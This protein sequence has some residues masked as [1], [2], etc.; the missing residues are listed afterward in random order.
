[1]RFLLAALALWSAAAFAQ[2]FPSKPVR[3]VPFGTAGGPVDTLARMYA[4]KLRVRW[5]QP[6][7]VEPRPGASGTL[8][9]DLV[10]KS[11]PD[12]ATF[13]FTLSL[14]HINNAVLQKNIP[15][16]PFRDFEPVSL[17]AIGYGPALLAP[18][19]APFSDL[20]G[21]VAYANSR[22]DGVSYGTWGTGSTPHLFSEMLAIKE[23]IKL[24]H[25]PYKGEAA[26]HLDL[27]GGALD[28]AWAN[29]GTARTHL[30]SGKVKVLGATGARRSQVLPDTPLF[31]EQGFEG[32]EI[33][34]WM[35]AF[36]PAKTPR[37]IV[38]ELYAALR[39]ATREPDITARWLD[40]GFEPVAST[41]GELA[42]VHRADYPKWEAIIKAVGIAPE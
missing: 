17:L 18:A 11:S 4:E 23:G 16:D 5:N 33:T 22:P 35:A 10:A 21:L 15:Y 6:V 2:P 32:F 42:R 36:A 37:P 26:A 20:R 40:I 38:A 19:G 41:P 7:I 39:D 9:A 24:V 30:K 3:I 8:A 14:T 28:L 1:M 13:L 31:G 34:T 27:L 25:V 12:G 29:S